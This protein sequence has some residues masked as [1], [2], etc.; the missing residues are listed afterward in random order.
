MRRS[1]KDFRIGPSFVLTGGPMLAWQLIF[2]LGAGVLLIL[3]TFWT[4]QNYRLVADYNWGNWTSILSS[5][6][7]Y[8]I[9]FRTVLYAAFAAVLATVL[10]FP[11]SYALAFKSS[12][13]TQRIAFMLLILPYFTNYYVRSYSWRFMLEDDGIINSAL[14]VF[15]L[16]LVGFQGSFAPTLVGY[17]GY[18]FPLVALVQLLSLMYISRDY[19]EAANNLGAGRLRS[20]VTVVIPMARSGL[21]LGFAFGFML[22]MGDYIAPS[23][24]GSGGRPTLS[25]LII[26][27]IQ[28]QSDFPRASVISVVMILTLMTVFFIAFRYAFPPRSNPR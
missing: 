21:I 8:T 15:G 18:F 9:Y 10:A 19:L 24:L 7:F 2:F 27:T 3:M 28:G 16:S 20:I 17:M 1:L 4:V 23:Y 12:P 25:I 26:N 5:D 22:A 13:R 11:L 6:L 14:S